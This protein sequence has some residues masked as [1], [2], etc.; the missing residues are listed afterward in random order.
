[1]KNKQQQQHHQQQQHICGSRHDLKLNLM[2]G[3]IRTLVPPV[4]N[5]YVLHS[6]T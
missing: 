1:M 6:N 2:A 5:M 4:G 3:V